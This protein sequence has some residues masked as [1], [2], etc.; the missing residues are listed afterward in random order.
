MVIHPFD[1]A[2]EVLRFYRDF[3]ASQPDEL[4][5]FAGILTS[6]DGHPAVA[7]VPFYV[8]PHDEGERIL[9]PLRQFGAPVADTIGPMAYVD[10]QSM[11][12][13]GFPYGRLN[14]HKTCLTDELNDAV[15]AAIVAAY[16]QV[17][18]PFSAILIA[19]FHGA[20]RRVGKTDTAYYHRD[21]RYDIVIAAEWAD[22]ADSERNLQWAREL[23]AAIQPHLP[24]AVYVN[25]LGHDECEERVRSAYGENYDRL[26]A[27][28]KK[29]DPSNPFQMNQ[30]IKPA[31]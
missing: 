22:A 20:F 24:R 8:G 25:D 1:R 11:F 23:H 5:I 10:V 3:T 12:D 18:S 31:N 27:L 14:Y 17:P 21:L 13:G 28:K 4:E 7:L 9:A 6:P 30:N 15:I 16:A 26:V 19:D 2:T 29:Y